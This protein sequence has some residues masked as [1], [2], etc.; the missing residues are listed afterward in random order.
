VDPSLA[1]AVINLADAIAR[2]DSTRLGSMLLPDGKATLD[3]LTGDGS[4]DLA[5]K[6][7]EAVRVVSLVPV[8]GGEPGQAS[9]GTVFLAIQDPG[10]AYVLGWSG[11]NADGSWRFSATPSTGMTKRRASDFDGMGSSLADATM[12]GSAPAAS[13]S[14]GAPAVTDVALSMLGSL[15]NDREFY[16]YVAASAKLAAQKGLPNAGDEQVLSML[17]SAVPTARDKFNAGK[18][19]TEAVS[20]QQAGKLADMLVAAD[21]IASQMLGTPPVTRDQALAAIAEVLGVP[22]DQLK[23]AGT[24]PGGG[25]APVGG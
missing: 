16:V 1:T 5:V 22:V 8:E 7:I 4:W 6:D 21:V 20:A 13:A 19:S 9:A 18:A 17:S 25:A 3:L 24:K 11:V 15:L 10:S 14:P 12:T 2:G 23:P